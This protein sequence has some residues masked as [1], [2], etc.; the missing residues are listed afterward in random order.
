MAAAD[1]S[2][3][4]ALGR[5]AADTLVDTSVTLADRLTA[6][7]A[8]V[9]RGDLSWDKAGALAGQTAT[10]TDDQAHA[11]EQR[12]LAKAPG[13]TPAQHLAA[14]RR[15]VDRVDPVGA[16]ERRR[17]AKRD[18]ALIRSHHGDGMGELFARMPSEQVD[19]VW[20]GA[21]AWA[22]R[23]K[24]RWRPPHPRPAP[25]RRPGRLGRVV[26][27]P[28]QPHLLRHPL[29]IVTPQHHRRRRWTGR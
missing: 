1:I 21:D 4:L 20:T 14:V 9:Q 11:V 7:Q 25:R 22:R 27:H 15:A 23:A 2:G 10:L 3:V 13:R 6:T 16:E 12:V 8:A 28:R 29:P 17:Q 24:G 19:T 26:P 18:I 5:G